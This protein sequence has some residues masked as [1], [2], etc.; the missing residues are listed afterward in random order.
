MPSLASPL[1]HH[2]RLHLAWRVLACGAL[3]AAACIQH[4]ALAL[5]APQPVVTVTLDISQL[6]AEDQANAQVTA[7]GETA[8]AMAQKQFAPLYW[9]LYPTAVMPTELKATLVLIRQ[10]DG[11]A[12]TGGGVMTANM[13]YFDA[14]SADV[15]AIFHELAHVVQAYPRND[16][17]WLTEG[18]ADWARYFWYEKHTLADYRRAAV[19]SYTDGYANASRFLEWLRWYRNGAIV[20]RLNAMMQADGSVTDEQWTQ[21][22]GAGLDALWQEYADW[23]AKHAGG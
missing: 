20:R 18:I 12:W 23:C 5:E 4:P 10:P 21:L 19:G 8:R 1:V 14:N 17:G 6:S 9:L 22:A 7:W 2:A 16:E 13:T 15:G 3:L 11:I